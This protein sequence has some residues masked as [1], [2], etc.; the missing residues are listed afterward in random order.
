MAA[1][2]P[3]MEESHH[4]RILDLAHGLNAQQ[5]HAGMARLARQVCPVCG[6]RM[7][8]EYER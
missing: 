1:A 2:T 4:A 6:E 7:T 8:K 3:R 5:F